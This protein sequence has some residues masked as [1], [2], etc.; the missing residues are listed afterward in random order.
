[1]QPRFVGRLSVAD[2]VTVGN[3]AI[4]FLAA[5]AT[6]GVGGVGLAARLILLAAIADAL[7][8]IL[9][10]R[11]GGSAAGEYLDSLADVASFGVAPALIVASVARE[12]WS[13]DGAPVAFGLGIA[14]PVAFVAMAV[15]R[16]GL[17]TAYDVESDSTEGVQTTL[18]ATVLAAGVLS[19]YIG[20]VRPM[21]LVGITG[22]LALMMVSTVGYP[23]L[24][25]QDALVMGVVQALAVLSTGFYGKVFAF[26]LLTLAMAY[27]TLGPRFYWRK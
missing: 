10:R 2:A 27:L 4:G 21:F 25:P 13:L 19:G 14:L 3:A 23:D 18:A 24:H 1:M 20:P 8:G 16:L 26:G 7:D 5:V 11:Y 12:T 17:Y 6:T 22:V 15:T 9:A